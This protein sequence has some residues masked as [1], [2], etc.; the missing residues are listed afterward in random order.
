MAQDG[1]GHG[2][3]LGRRP[4][5]VVPAA[6]PRRCRFGA[7]RRI[8]VTRGCEPGSGG[9]RMEPGVRCRGDRGRDRREARPP[10]RHVDRRRDQRGIPPAGPRHDPG[11]LHPGRPALHGRPVRRRH[12]VL[13]HRHRDRRWRDDR[14]AIG[15]RG[16]P[17]DPAV[18]RRIA[19]GAAIIILIVAIAV[20]VGHP[21]R[22]RRG[23]PRRRSGRSDR[24][25][26]PG[27]R[28]GQRAARARRDP[29]GP[30]HAP[31]RAAPARPGAGPDRRGRARSSRRSARAALPHGSAAGSTGHR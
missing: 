16:G 10:V 1:P 17:Y 3:R 29:A 15:H 31:P 25:R 8:V 9:R 23:L 12:V 11:R 21:G 30:R 24:G 13:G 28:G 20:G 18:A 14:P 26:P 27:P 7:A 6:G 22:G 19:L 5:R 2:R 4:A